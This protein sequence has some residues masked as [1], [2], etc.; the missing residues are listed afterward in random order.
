[1]IKDIIKA[2]VIYLSLI[3]MASCGTNNENITI[4]TAIPIEEVKVH[5]EVYTQTAEYNGD[6]YYISG[7]DLFKDIENPQLIEEGVSG[8]Q[9]YNSILYYTKKTDDKEIVVAYD[10]A[11]KKDLFELPGNEYSHMIIDNNNCYVSVSSGGDLY[12]KSFDENDFIM[13]KPDRILYAVQDTKLYCINVIVPEGT[14][15]E[16]F[17]DIDSFQWKYKLLCIDVSDNSEKIIAENEGSGFCITPISNGIA[18]CDRSKNKI[19]S[20]INGES[21]YLCDGNISTMLSSDDSIIFSD[22]QD[23]ALYRFS[24]NTGTK[25]KI[26]DKY[27]PTF[28]FINGW[29]Y[30]GTNWINIKQTG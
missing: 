30:N 7:G 4:H 20:Y 2:S 11:V 27:I 16:Y 18:Y 15:D 24:L 23:P 8:I 25:E 1:M 19:Y 14:Y 5:N 13:L 6:V 29:I 10:G 17:S 9:N 26:Y 12:K 3:I 28:G 22:S 21:K